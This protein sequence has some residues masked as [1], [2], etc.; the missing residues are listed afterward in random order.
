MSPWGHNFQYLTFKLI[1]KD[2]EKSLRNSD[3]SKAFIRVGVGKG[4]Q[5]LRQQPSL[6]GE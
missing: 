3:R 1:S 5:S 4:R 6:N 2:E